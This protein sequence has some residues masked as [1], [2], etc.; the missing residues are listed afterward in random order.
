MTPRTR[1]ILATSILTL[2]VAYAS[3]IALVTIPHGGPTKRASIVAGVDPDG[4]M[5]F[6]CDVANSTAG[7][8]DDEAGHA[9][10]RVAKRDR[11]TIEVRTDDGRRHGHDFKLEGF[12]YAIWPAGIEMELESREAKTFTAW[13]A[14]TYRFV[15]EL[16]GHEDRGM[17]GELV[18]S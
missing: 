8:C 10:V 5:Y 6:R 13:R 7:T 17:W 11:L 15:C 18:V 2:V 4:T 14:G 1:K 3:H 9:T 12:A 16:A